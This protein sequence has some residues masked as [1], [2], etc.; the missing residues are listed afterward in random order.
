MRYQIPTDA[1]AIDILDEAEFNLVRNNERAAIARGRAKAWEMHRATGPSGQ[2]RSLAQGAVGDSVL[3][4]GYT[5]SKQI[6]QLIA[7]V[8]VSEGV[9]FTCKLERSLVDGSPVGVRVTLAAFTR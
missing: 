8:S 7:S 2:L 4:E 3:L 6:S 9:Q 5:S 1:E